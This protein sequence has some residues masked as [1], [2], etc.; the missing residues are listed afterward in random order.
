MELP[1]AGFPGVVNFKRSNLPLVVDVTK[2]VNR[3]IQVP[4]ITQCIH[5][6][7]HSSE[8]AVISS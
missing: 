8:I 6:Q 2:R 7:P 3:T 4:A 5:G 1:K